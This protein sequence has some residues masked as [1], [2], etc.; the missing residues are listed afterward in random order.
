MG[1]MKRASAEAEAEHL[2][3][4]PERPPRPAGSRVD[5]TSSVKWWPSAATR[6]CCSP[7][8]RTRSSC[9]TWRLKAFRLGDRKVEL[10]FPLVHIDT[11]HN[12][13]EVIAFRDQ[14]A[15]ELGARLV[16]GHVEDSIKRGTVRLR[17]RNATRATPRKP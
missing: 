9:C 10:P 8:A 16:V 15:A 14:R 5:L 3:Q 1:I 11:G 13:Q 12:Y 17:S 2:L 7:A 6:R 4:C